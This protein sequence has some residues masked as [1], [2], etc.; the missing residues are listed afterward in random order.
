MGKQLKGL[1]RFN[2]FMTKSWE[3]SKTKVGGVI[4]GVS[5]ILHGV[6]GLLSKTHDANTAYVMIMAGVGTIITIIGARDAI[7]K[8]K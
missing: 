4:V 7:G 5:V 2:L 3:W 8:K 6:G 1:R